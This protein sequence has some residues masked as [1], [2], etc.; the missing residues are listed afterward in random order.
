MAMPVVG[1]VLILRPDAAEAVLAAAGLVITA[2][3]Q[4]YV[5]YQRIRW[6]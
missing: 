1:I 2:M 4:S 5:R 3:R 6:T